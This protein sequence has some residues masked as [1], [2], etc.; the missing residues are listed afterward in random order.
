MPTLVAKQSL[1]AR[2]ESLMQHNRK[3]VAYN[4]DR[5]IC[6]G[7]AGYPSLALARECVGRVMDDN[8]A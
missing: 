4:V 8:L 5:S 7:E 2:M 6:G 3:V 1:P